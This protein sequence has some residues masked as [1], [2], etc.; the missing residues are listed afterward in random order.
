MLLKSKFSE[1]RNKR[2]DG[3]YYRLWIFDD[4]LS[5]C[6]ESSIWDFTEAFAPFIF[7]EDQWKKSEPGKEIE[8][9][10]KEIEIATSKITMMYLNIGLSGH[11]VLVN[12]VL[13]KQVRTDNDAS[14]VGI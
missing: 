2:I 12:C 7:Y 10:G 14:G 1:K 8:I 9:A 3:I 5:P 11:D 13:I 4:H 6:K